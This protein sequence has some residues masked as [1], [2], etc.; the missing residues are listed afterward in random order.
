MEHETV[1][2]IEQNGLE[3]EELSPAMDGSPKGKKRV[4]EKPPQASARP[5]KRR[6]LRQVRK[7]V[8]KKTAKK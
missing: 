1:E 2:E 6:K 7:R 3:Q 8:P 4:Q 5:P